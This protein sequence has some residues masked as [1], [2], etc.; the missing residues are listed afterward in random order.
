MVRAS[1]G[2][3]NTVFALLLTLAVAA[4]A[5]PPSI[6]HVVVVV[7]ENEDAKRADTQPYL[8]ELSARGAVLNNYHALTH[9]SQPNY[10]ALVAG[11][12]FDVKNDRPVVLDVRHLGNLLEEKGL[13][14][15]TYAENYPG[16]CSLKEHVGFPF[17]SQYVQRHVPFLRFKNVREDP[18]RCARIV[19]ASVLDQDVANGTLPNF[20]L[21]IPNNSNNGHDTGVERADRFLR[22]RFEPL[23]RDPRFADGTLFVVTFDEGSDRGPNV[24]YT[25]LVG[26]GVRPGA[27]SGAWYDHYSLLRTIEEIFGTGTLGRHDDEASAIGDVWANE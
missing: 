1:H 3:V 16:N 17:R 8:K 25:V 14:W 11:S 10:I 24:I 26:A 27:V 13:T 21:Y 15:K 2:S 19:N 9:P 22:K 18:T 12:A 23:L 6:K 5:P 4:T 20:A 7:L